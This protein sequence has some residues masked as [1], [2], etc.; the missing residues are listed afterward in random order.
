MNNNI[1]ANVFDRY[2]ITPLILSAYQGDVN[3]LKYLIKNGADVNIRDRMNLSALDHACQRLNTEPIREL[4]ICGCKC[5]SSTP[6]G[7]QSPLKTLISNKEFVLAR[8]LIESGLDLKNEKW[9]LSELKNSENMNNSF[10]KWLQ[11]ILKTPSSSY[12]NLIFSRERFLK[13][14]FRDNKVI[15]INIYFKLEYRIN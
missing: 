6:F 12:F 15:N 10:F 11:N 5:S 1:I 9:L 3:I 14:E 8:M 7:L 13:L 2:S 4:I